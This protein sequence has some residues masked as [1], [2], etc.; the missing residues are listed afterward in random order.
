MPTLKVAIVGCGQIADAHLQAARRSGLA[1][2]VAVCDK[3]PDLARQ[4]AVRFAVPQWD[5]DF[6]RMLDRTQPDVVHITT[7]PAAHY[8]LFH[9]AIDAGSH[10]YVEKPFSL[11]GAEACEMLASAAARG[12]LV[13]TGHDRLF[14]PSWV[15]CRKR[16]R[17]GAIGAVTHAEFFQSYDLGGPFG[18]LFTHDDRH[19]VR[20]LP[21]GLFQNA[22]P[23]ALAAIGE[24]IRDEQ[25]LVTATSWNKPPWDFDTELLV[26]VRGAHVSAT[27]TLVT[28]S[29]PATSYVRVYGHDG[30]LEVDYEARATRLRSAS[31][32]PSLLTKLHAPWSSTMESIRTLSR[33]AVGLLRG[34]LQYFAGLQSLVRLFYEAALQDG[35]SPIDP[36]E[37]YRVAILMDAVISDLNTPRQRATPRAGVASA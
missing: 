9:M 28:G 26:L 5:S 32:L 20:Q 24:L 37:V 10:V 22:I 1:R 11:N 7:P 33:N 29:R 17:A 13:C 12:R 18:R 8:R 6:A 34:N 21:G 15:E 2:V 25:L 16:I 36:S 23:H 30:W 35:R 14:D 27:L 3:S 19:W 4:A 31:A